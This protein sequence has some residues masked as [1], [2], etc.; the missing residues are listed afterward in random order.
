MSSNVCILKAFGVNGVCLSATALA[1][2]INPI[3]DR[4]FN[5]NLM[6]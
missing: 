4:R 6:L 5:T 1:L 2:L 3:F